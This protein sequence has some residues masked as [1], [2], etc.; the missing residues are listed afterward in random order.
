MR[1]LFGA[2]FSMTAEV[3]RYSNAAIDVPVA[4]QVGTGTWS[5]NQDP[6]TGE[7]IS[8]WVPGTTDNPDTPGVVD[9]GDSRDIPC[10]VQGIYNAGIRASGTDEKFGEEYFNI[11]YLKMWVPAHVNISKADRITNI[12][13]AIGNIVYFDEEYLDGTRST[14]FDV[15]GVTPRYDYR[16][17]P[18]DKF[19][20]LEKTQ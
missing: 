8:T 6:I 12:R 19:I 3:L 11:E 4:A 10:F 2:R 18:M 7:I 14:I 20:M 16:N 13:D 15:R 9:P 1:C 5:N 17:I